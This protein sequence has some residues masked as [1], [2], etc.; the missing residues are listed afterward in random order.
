MRVAV[1]GLVP[2]AAYTLTHE[3]VDQDHSN[4][5]AAW[6]ALRRDGQDWPDDDQWA[7]LRVGGPARRARAGADRRGRRDGAVLVEFEL[8]MPSMSLLTLTPTS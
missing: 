5:A 4:V 3:R 2:G 8:P 7:A 1:S 6:G